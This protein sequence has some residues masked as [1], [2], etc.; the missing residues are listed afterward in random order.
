MN[1][2]PRRAVNFKSRLRT[3][4]DL[5]FQSTE[6][7]AKEHI[8]RGLLRQRK[9]P[10]TKDGRIIDLDASRYT[11]L[12]D[13]RTGYNYPNNAISSS[14][15]TIWTFLPLQFWFQFTKAQNI[16]FLIMAALQLVP[17]LSTTGSFTTLL[18]L[19]V[20][21]VFSMAREGYDDF[22]RYKLDKIENRRFS[23]VLYGYRPASVDRQASQTLV[24]AAQLQWKSLRDAIRRPAATDRAETFSVSATEKNQSVSTPPASTLL[25]PSLASEPDPWSPTISGPN[26]WATTKWNSL[27]VGDIIELK[28]KHQVPADIVLLHADG[29]NGVAYIETMALDGE[30][31]LKTRQPLALLAE[32]YNTLVGL[33]TY[34][35]QFAVEDPNLHFYEF[36]G[37]VTVGELLCHS[38]LTMLYI[39]DA[40]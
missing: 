27:K 9:L 13:E 14:R 12:L 3:T 18:P 4:R 1:T 40:R 2:R 5:I 37:K 8:W 10:K 34:R 19:M 20:F 26:P 25:T 15:Y 28:R 6:S 29:R 24:G 16:F 17:G 11:S 21:F 35:A 38:H 22:R 39:G 23:R 30:T 7:L 32:K 31:N 36:N 33:S